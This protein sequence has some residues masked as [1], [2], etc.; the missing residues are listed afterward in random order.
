M[1]TMLKKEGIRFRKAITS[2][3]SVP[4]SNV[5][6]VERETKRT[7]ENDLVIEK[8]LFNVSHDFSHSFMFYYTPILY[9]DGHL[10]MTWNSQSTIELLYGTYGQTMEIQA[11][12]RNYTGTVVW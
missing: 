9:H 8:L 11:C 3:Q 2:T 6:V 4:L 1:I 10:L 12:M 7:T 5:M